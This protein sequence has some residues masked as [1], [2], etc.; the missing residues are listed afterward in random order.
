VLHRS[1]E[2][3]ILN[4]LGLVLKNQREFREAVAVLVRAIELRRGL[5][6]GPADVEH[7]FLGN[8]LLNLGNAYVALNETKAAQGALEESLAIFRDR[9][10]AWPEWPRFPE[11]VCLSSLGALFLQS[12]RPQE[13]IEVFAEGVSI[14][15]ELHH[16][17]QLLLS[18]SSH[19][20]ATAADWQPVLL[21]AMSQMA[22]SLQTLNRCSEA[23]SVYRDVFS[24]YEAMPVNSR[25][26]VAP[27]YGFT[28]S[29]YADLLKTLGKDD[30]ALIACRQA[31]S[32]AENSVKSPGELHYYKGRVHSS[33][34]RVLNE[35]ISRG[36]RGDLFRCLTAL[37]EGA[38]TISH[39]EAAG[40]DAAVEVLAERQKKLGRELRVLVVHTLG[41]NSVL[42]AIMGSAR[43]AL[44]VHVSTSFVEKGGRLFCEIE[45]S[46]RPRGSDVRTRR[47]H[48]RDVGREAWEA[49]PEEVRR[50]LASSFEGD[51]LVSADSY[52]AAFPWE[53]LYD[54]DWVGRHH[55]LPR[56]S[57]ISALELNKLQRQACGGGYKVAAVVCPW[58]AVQGRELPLAREEATTVADRLRAAGYSLVK[59]Q[60]ILGQSASK[61]GMFEIISNRPAVIHYTGHGAHY[62]DEEVLLLA[63]LGGC[64]PFGP[65][66]L[67]QHK[68]R[69]RIVGGL[70]GYEPLVVLN[71][72]FSGE[73]R[74]F[75][76]R[77]EDFVSTL[78]AEGAAAVIACANPVFD[79]MGYQF[80]AWLYEPNE[81]SAPM[82]V[83]NFK[84]SRSRLDKQFESDESPMWP[85]WTLFH[86]H[87]NPY[88]MLP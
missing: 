42:L 80:G 65:A 74:W 58:D 59:G 70:L 39:T 88:V 68:Q 78:M 29:D 51:L 76:G 37:R 53:A 63:G 75:G 40:Y 17:Q 84:R 54:E 38:G 72:C 35:C 49:L 66:D 57:G 33:Y 21:I 71:S 20:P 19:L 16:E 23:E 28:L 5:T 60:A 12:G 25:R 81:S 52:W 14:L 83:E 3:A 9:R 8:A 1:Q 13:A 55:A 82:V 34:I 87:G 41:R 43:K 86:F 73:N 50:V 79:A 61:P 48:L 4:S 62:F 24:L 26:A 44:E 46:M 7:E 45:E 77:R 32:H 85:L 64:D 30:D 67:R 69:E 10:K 56:W 2:A 31:I 47:Q 11:G 36:E 18:K 15:R 22:S 27:D 6:S